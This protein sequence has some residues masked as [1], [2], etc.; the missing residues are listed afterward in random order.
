[1]QYSQ[2]SMTLK[3]RVMQVVATIPSGKVMY[4]GQI[5]Q[6]TGSNARVVGWILSGLTQ[7]ECQQVPWHRVVAK[8]GF[9]SSLKL[10]PKGILQRQKLINEGYIIHDNVVD[11]SIHVLM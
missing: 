10:G 9:I 11:M 7:E 2:D 4:F 3:Q 6:I 8:N 1:M 5:A